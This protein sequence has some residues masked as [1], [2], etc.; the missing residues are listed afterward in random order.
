VKNV[1][2]YVIYNVIPSLLLL[3]CVSTTEAQTKCNGNDVTT[4]DRYRVRDVTVETLFRGSPPELKSALAKHRGE[5][6]LT[7]GEDPL[8]STGA[9]STTPTRNR[10]IEEVQAFFAEGENAVNQ[11]R[12]AGINQQNAFYVRATYINDCVTKVPDT[13]CR[14]TLKDSQ[15]NPVDKCLDIKVKIKVVPINTGNLSAN[16]LDLARSNKL[17]FYRELPKGLRTFNPAF[18]IDYDRDYGTTAVAQA[19]VDLLELAAPQDESN[20]AGNTQLHLAFDGHKSLQKRFYDTTSVLSVSRVRPV[21]TLTKLGLNAS[22]SAR[23]EPQGNNVRFINSLRIGAS[24]S[25]NLSKGPLT[26]LSLGLNY[27]HSGNRLENSARLLVENRTE[28]A[29]ESRVFADGKVARGFVRGAIWFDGTNKAASGGDAY[30]RLAATVG[31][32][33]EFALRRTACHIITTED[34]NACEF[35][36]TNA[37]AVG[38]EMLFGAG[39]AWGQV[40]EY[41][42]FYGGNS[43]GN[44]LYDAVNEAAP[45]DMPNGPLIRSFGRNQAG[46]RVNLKN[47]RGGT[48]YWHYNLSL[49]I[50]LKKFSRPLIPAEVVTSVPDDSGHLNCSGCTSLKDALKN[51]VKGEK[52]I[53]IDAMAVRNLTEQQREDLALDP[54]D[55]DDP[56]TPEEQARL[57]AA[58]RAFEEQ[59]RLVQPEADRVWKSLTPT[60]EYIADHANLYAIRPLIMFDAARIIARET[61][62]QRMCVALGGGIQFNVVV[63]KFEVGYQRTVRSMPGD[64]KGNFVVRMVFEKF[65]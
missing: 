3:V 25:L 64:Q 22:F 8:I 35:P 9:S 39:R 33:R 61:P 42:R 15:G 11:D 10:Y 18:W 63:A 59:R 19:T 43:A 34:G 1:V 32:A 41:A 52:N 14:A 53:F 55:P 13:E 29:F 54:D 48:A 60:I 46:A 45:L 21:D 50:P 4:E 27:R 44:F 65:F 57:A 6:Y 62:N 28:S 5:M 37:P 31:Y 16:L 23:E 36:D 47:V 20:P 56:L 49:A 30:H 24:T 58:D 17:R 12:R 7:S 26:K 51:Q 40:P 38:V 2:T